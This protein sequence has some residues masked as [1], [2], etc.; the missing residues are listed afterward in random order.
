MRGLKNIRT[1]AV[2]AA[3]VMSLTACVQ[4]VPQATPDAALNEEPDA[5]GGL[6]VQYEDDLY[7]Q[8]ENPNGGGLLYKKPGAKGANQLVTELP[9]VGWLQIL[10]DTFY[11]GTHDKGIYRFH[12]DGSELQKISD[13]G[14]NFFIMTPQWIFGQTERYNTTQGW[15]GEIYRMRPDGSEYTVLSKDGGTCL[16]LYEETL[17]YFSYTDNA[18]VKMN[19]D[20]AEKE[21]LISDLRKDA[22]E[23]FK[24]IPP[25]ENFISKYSMTL[26]DGWIYYITDYQVYKVLVDG[27]ENTKLN[28]AA[29]ALAVKGSELVLLDHNEGDDPLG[30]SSISMMDQNGENKRVVIQSGGWLPI[31]AGEYVYFYASPSLYRFAATGGG[32]EQIY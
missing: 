3:F 17:Y 22:G 31:V 29:K 6:I 13:V 19:M 15:E 10:D 9:D 24:E 14:G 11:L 23:N 16:N 2:I 30:S 26:K 8:V 27:Q 20:G 25:A 21:T 12:L 5:P 1:A 4:H 18:I 28:A 7:F 32:F